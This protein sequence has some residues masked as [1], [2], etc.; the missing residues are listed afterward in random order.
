VRLGFW[1]VF[2]I[3]FPAMTGVESIVSLSGD[4][5]RPSHSIPLG[6]ILA[7]LVAY[8]VYVCVAVFVA[9]KVPLDLLAA[10]P[11]I[12]QSVASIP[13]LIILGIW[14]ATL[15]SALGGLVSAP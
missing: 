7:S 4:L 9:M 15:S 1:S 12:L 8:L 13:S 2:A 6:T 10:D 3:F 14:S 5:K 11:L